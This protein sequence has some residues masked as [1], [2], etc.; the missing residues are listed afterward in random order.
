MEIKIFY[1]IWVCLDLTG[2]LLMT[3]RSDVD[4]FRNE[5]HFIMTKGTFAHKITYV[6]IAI[7]LLP[8]TIPRSIQEL[9]RK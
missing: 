6:L 3:F 2:L 8:L 7:T 5:A 9:L 1:I 4:K